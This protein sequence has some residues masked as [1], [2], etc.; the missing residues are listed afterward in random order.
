[1]K[2]NEIFSPTGEPLTLN[3]GIALPFGDA[4][5][6]RAA[7]GVP[8]R[9]S[10]DKIAESELPAAVARVS[11]IVKLKPPTIW[12]PE[13][14]A[15]SANQPF[16]YGINRWGT[17][18]GL[19]FTVLFPSFRWGNVTP[20]AYYQIFRLCPGF[21]A[22]QNSFMVNTA[23]DGRLQVRL[24]N[25]PTVPLNGARVMTSTEVFADLLTD[26]SCILLSM[27]RSAPPT[28]EIDGEEVAMTESVSTLGTPPSDWTMSLTDTFTAINTYGSG[29][30]SLSIE[31]TPPIILLGTLSEAERAEFARSR[32]LPRWA[33]FPCKPGNQNSG[34]LVI[35]QRYRITTTGGTFTSVGAAN[36][37]AGTEFIAT[38][39]TPTWGTGTVQPLGMLA[40]WQAPVMGSRIV[41]DATRQ[42]T[43]MVLRNAAWST[44]PGHK[45]R[46]TGT[47]TWS[48]ASNAQHVIGV[49]ENL[50]RHARVR[51]DS[52][53]LTSTANVTVDIGNQNT[54]D[55]YVDDASLVANTPHEAT[56]IKRYPAGTADN[57]LRLLIKPTA[58]FTGSISVVVEATVMP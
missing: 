18:G 19:P 10:D 56:L 21:T 6:Q 9:D 36:N 50:W 5:A 2:T 7:L 15:A 38:G 1:M 57:E 31:F 17:I 48:A 8:L 20:S 14:A 55:Y 11:Q 16:V 40:H 28:V 3:R 27:P 45:V 26:D 51:I 12:L 4:A 54:A 35:G 13:V 46:L 44:V 29:F 42:G 49:A 37:D 25:S 30:G 53:N 39:D 52:I 58:S 41:E 22:F 34:S 32:R 23:S 43:E 33:T 47:L 24:I